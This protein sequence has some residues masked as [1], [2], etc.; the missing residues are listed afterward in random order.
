MEIQWFGNSTFLIKSS[1]GKKLLIDPF[2]T[3]K[4]FNISICPNIVSISK[5]SWVNLNNNL[6]NQ[7]TKIIYSNENYFDD[8]IKVKGYLSYSDKLLGLKR[9]KNIIFKY[10]FDD[11]KLCHLGYLGE[12]LNDELIKTLK[13]MDILFIPIGGSI[14]LDGLSA[15]KLSTLLCPK[16]IIPMCYKSFNSDFYFD[17]PKNFLSH[18]KS[19]YKHNK[20]VLHISELNYSSLPLT[21]L[22]NDSD[23]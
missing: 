3:L 14:C 13:N 1:L 15:Y 16:Y 11:Y 21:I 6:I 5:N 4:T 22:L 9:G 7:S 23:I 2:N 20:S 19:I 8:S 12:P 10:E 18:C 17:G